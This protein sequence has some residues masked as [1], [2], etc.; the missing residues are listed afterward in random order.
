[1]PKCC[2]TPTR[3]VPT[4]PIIARLTVTQPE[5]HTLRYLRPRPCRL[6]STVSLA[7]RRTS[8]DRRI[9]LVTQGEGSAS[10]TRIKR[11]SR[12]VRRTCIRFTTSTAAR[13]GPN[14]YVT[15]RGGRP[16]RPPRPAPASSDPSTAIHI[17]NRPSRTDAT[18]PRTGDPGG[19]GS[20]S[21]RGGRGLSRPPPYLV[22]RPRESERV[23]PEGAT[24]SARSAL[25]ADAAAHAHSRRMSRGTSASGLSPMSC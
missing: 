14:A 8:I 11:A 20:G 17:G 10:A 4:V 16:M 9:P 1:M 6:S 12:F 7:G 13:A 15:H 18:T 19:C 5:A 3:G 25:H 22:L 23:V 24:R 2:S 21:V